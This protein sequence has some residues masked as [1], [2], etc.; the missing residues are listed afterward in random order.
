[1]RK[2]IFAIGLL[3]ASLSAPIFAADLAARPYTKAPMAPPA[4]YN[5]GG[6]YIGGNGGYGWGQ[7]NWTFLLNG[8]SPNHSTS[9]GLAG[10]QVGYNWQLP[11]SWVFGLEADGDWADIKGS[12]PCPNRLFACASS[13]RD[14]ASFRGR[15]GYAAGP[16]LFYGTGGLGYANATYSALLSAT[17]TSGNPAATGRYNTD[18]W[19]YAAGAG[20]EWGFAPSWS[21]KLEYMHYGFDRATA[22]AGTLSATSTSVLGLDVDTVKVGVN[23]HFGW[24]NPM[25]ARY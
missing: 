10:G 21:A 9:G 14:L 3:T 19:G 15:V 1:M 12:T 25:V 13:T 22:P 2:S 16:V 23:Y 8:T 18:R 5:W 20:I 17:G 4:V 11:S 24:T 7:T 6:F